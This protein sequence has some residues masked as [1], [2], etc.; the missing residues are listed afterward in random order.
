M[1]HEP[2]MISVTVSL[3]NGTAIKQFHYEV[4]NN[5]KLS[6]LAMMATVFN[7]L[8]GI[9]DYG[10]D[11]TYRMNG[12]LSVKGYP[13][14]TMRNMF[15]PTDSGNPAAAQAAASIGDR[16]GRIYS[17][18]YD[19]P[20]VEGV[21][22]DFDL[23]RDRRSA[24]LETSR[25]DVTEARP[26]DVI[27]V[28][29]VIRPYRG[30]RQVCQIPIR[31]P[32]SAS[33]GPLRLL[34]SDGDTLDRMRRAAPATRGLGLAPTI[35]LL[36]KERSNDRVYVSLFD[37]DPEAM[38]ADKIM[39]TL[40]LSVMNVMD[41]MRGTQDMVVLGESSVSEAS[42]EPLDYVVTG[43]QMLTINIK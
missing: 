32:T 18:P 26:G 42:T 24:H 14:V 30:E 22:L 10:D 33:K 28:E 38:V 9:N 43:A 39:P 25:T 23:V 34:V 20:D 16:F 8:H 36:N 4:L 40:P 27:T 15:A 17:N 19:A 6:P 35:A 41:N 5:A 2:K 1:G 3:H 21:K 31:I 13:D 37:S 29:T 11:L 12:V 7:A